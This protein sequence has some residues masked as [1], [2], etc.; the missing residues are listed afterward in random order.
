VREVLKWPG[1]D[2]TLVELDPAM[3]DLAKKNSSF[4]MLN[5]DS[6]NDPRVT[7]VAGDA[8]RYLV[9][10][11]RQ[12]GV[13][14]ADFPDPHDETISKLYTAEFFSLI[15]RSLRKGGV[16]VTQSTSPYFARE[17]FWCINATMK[18]VFR[19][20]VP[21]HV[22][23]PSF[24]DWGFNLAMERPMDIPGMGEP[25]KRLRHYT[26]ETFMQA[27]HFPVDSSETSVRINTFN[28]PV[29]YRYYL[30][31]WKQYVEE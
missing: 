9:A 24:G 19:H 4:R 17:A 16:F 14:I 6:L 2:V 11:R 27:L 5:G 1:A 10:H 25:P 30:R 31:G 26:G 12:F 28:K 13:I 22:Y 21:Y 29:L 20:V 8:Y 18:T 15:R 7:I 23:V 3:L